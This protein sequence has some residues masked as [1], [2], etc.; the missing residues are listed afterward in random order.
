MGVNRPLISRKLIN[1]K[2]PKVYVIGLARL[3]TLSEIPHR[4]ILISSQHVLDC[5]AELCILGCREHR[6][7]EVLPKCTS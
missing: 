3:A 2:E 1:G 5:I 7:T 6:G 4:H